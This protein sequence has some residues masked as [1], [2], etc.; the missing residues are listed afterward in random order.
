MKRRSLAGLDPRR[1]RLAL[2][3]FFLALA[4]P[5][6][7]LVHQAYDQLKWEAFHQYRILAEELSARIDGRIGRLIAKEESR[8]YAD[9]GF[10][11]VAGDPAVNFLQPSPLSAFPVSSDIPGLLGYFQVDAEGVFSTPLVPASQA[12]AASYGISGPELTQRRELQ[13]QI[14]LVLSRNQLVQGP[15]AAELEANLSTG[16]KGALGR[17]IPPSPARSGSKP[18]VTGGEFYRSKGRPA[19][20]EKAK[21]QAAFDRL[22]QIREAT[23]QDKKSELAAAPEGTKDSSLDLRYQ[24][25]PAEESKAFPSRQA[26]GKLRGRAMRKERSLLPEPSPRAAPME[27]QAEQEADEVQVPALRVSIFESE[28]DPFQLSLL[29]SGHFVLYRK[30]WRDG[31]RSIQGALIEQAAFLRGTVE[32]AFRDSILS[33]MSDLAVADH[34][35]VLA[36]YGAQTGQEYLSS[37]GKLKGDLLYRAR[38]SSPA[39]DLELVFS[40]DRLPAGPGARV[41]GWTAASLV[42]VLCGGFLLMDR[43]GRKQIALA[44]QQQDF[45]SAV[46]HELK[47]PLTSIRM[48]AEMLREDWADEG[49]KQTYYAF[50]CEESERLTRLI[51]NVLQL[52]RLT[53]N[54]LR[55]DLKATSLGELAEA[56]RPKIT[57]L[58]DRAG[59]ALELDYTQCAE[60]AIMADEDFL[61]QILINLTDNAVKFARD[62]ERKEIRITCGMPEPGQVQLRVRDYG[63]GVPRDQMKKIFKLFYR[64][65]NELT[66]ETVGT[67]IGLALV[68]ELTLAM[69]GR[70]DLVNSQPGAEFRLTFP[71]RL[72]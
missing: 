50:I 55:I 70:V 11:V 45:V 14:L 67:G 19:V 48:Y 25:E 61:T 4:V 39:S 15:R 65:G 34:G 37:T 27:E 44:R 43:L 8:S 52:A 46:S 20:E 23:L 21:A 1:L 22:D 54:E 17:S 24:Q 53:R 6:G 71:V 68:R 38:L 64:S 7:I 69:G 42:L 49:R 9:Y 63:P 26:R 47:T 3:L 40:I 5:A 18:E 2:A 12:M 33:R 72:S 60:I 32:A 59:F 66:R 56:I 31:A 41:L 10:L 57:S 28:L 62:A 16:D 35:D 36:A 51:N 30:V 13:E 58:T 29:D